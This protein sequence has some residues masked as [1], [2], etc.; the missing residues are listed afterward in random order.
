MSSTPIFDQ[1]MDEFMAERRWTPLL[2]SSQEYYSY[3]VPSPTPN[4]TVELL[5]PLYVEVTEPTVESA[6][7]WID[8]MDRDINEAMNHLT[9]VTFTATAED[10]LSKMGGAHPF[11]DLM[12]QHQNAILNPDTMPTRELVG[13]LPMVQKEAE[14]EEP[15]EEEQHVFPITREGGRVKFLQD[16]DT[17]LIKRVRAGLHGLLYDEVSA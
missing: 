1:L 13:L 6:D 17:S 3:D 10:V 9:P 7:D 16:P 15:V 11:K 4:D 8:R 14:P 5:E 2:A 12:N